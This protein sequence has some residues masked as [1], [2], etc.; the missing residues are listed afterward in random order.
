M[1]EMVS[2]STDLIVLP[3]NMEDN[4]MKNQENSIYKYEGPRK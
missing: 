1:K 4:S 3:R 2:K